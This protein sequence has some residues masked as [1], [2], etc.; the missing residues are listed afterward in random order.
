MINKIYRKS[1]LTGNTNSME[2]AL[3]EHD[4]KIRN[5]KTDD[6]LRNEFQ[7]LSFVERKF[8]LTG[9]TLEEDIEKINTNK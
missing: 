5:C 6:A 7:F 4:I 1:Q 3:S 9:I 2:L 8:L